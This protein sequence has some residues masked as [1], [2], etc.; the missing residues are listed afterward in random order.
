MRVPIDK[1]DIE[2]FEN[3]DRSFIINNQKNILIWLQDINWPVAKEV[4]RAVRPYVNELEKALLEI[5]QGNDY[6][7]RF[8][9][10]A[11][12]LYF[13]DSIPDTLS[14]QLIKIYH[15]PNELED[16]KEKCL[17]VLEEFN[18]NF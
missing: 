5:L 10:V 7:W 14:N 11:S 2:A 15:D 16:L 8:N 6:E 12:V 1:F 4:S 9:V 18:I 3:I 17:E 13:C